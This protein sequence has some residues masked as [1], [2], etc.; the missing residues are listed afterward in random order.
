MAARLHGGRG[1]AC[2]DGMHF[3]FGNAGKPPYPTDRI[4]GMHGVWRAYGMADEPTG[5]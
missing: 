2:G 4:G 1:Y 5:Y 3:Q